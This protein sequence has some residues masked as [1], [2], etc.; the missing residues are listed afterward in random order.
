MERSDKATD[1]L[2][3]IALDALGDLSSTVPT[4]LAGLRALLRYNREYYVRST[5]DSL[6]SSDDGTLQNFHQSVDEALAVIA[7]EA[8]QS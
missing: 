6:L 1:T 5:E 3:Y 2:G 7:R 4:T 8:V